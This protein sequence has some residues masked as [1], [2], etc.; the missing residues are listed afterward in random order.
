M[1]QKEMEK[2]YLITGTEQGEI[3]KRIVQETKL[4]E[5]IGNYLVSGFSSKLRNYRYFDTFDARLTEKEVYTYIGPLEQEGISMSAREREHDY[6]LTVKFP[7][8]DINEREEHEFPIPTGTDFYE[9]NPDDFDFWGPMKRAK[10]IGR[11]RPLQEIL[12][13]EVETYR[14]DLKLNKNHVVQLAIDSVAVKGSFNIEKRF[15]ELEVEKCSKGEESD[16][17][18]VSNFLK[19]KYAGYLK[20]APQA[21]WIKARE[22]IR[23]ENIKTIEEE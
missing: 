12:R 15:Y 14:F 18:A 13:L 7:T 21:K 4:A 8:E 9:L 5:N 20:L 6:V 19:Q 1:P 10:S 16:L 23:G 11:D 2:K 17:L 22:L 3:F